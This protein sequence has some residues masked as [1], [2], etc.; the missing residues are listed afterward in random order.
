MS[1]FQCKL[2]LKFPVTVTASEAP[3]GWSYAAATTSHICYC[4]MRANKAHLFVWDK[5]M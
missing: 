1:T 2:S 4:S 5:T 3:H